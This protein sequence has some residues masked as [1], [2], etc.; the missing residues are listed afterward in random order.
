M[1]GIRPEE[2]VHPAKRSER[3]GRERAAVHDRSGG[4]FQPPKV[5]TQ[6]RQ[7][8]DALEE[9]VRSGHELLV[10]QDANVRLAEV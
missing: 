10:G 9:S 5:A 4:L 3:E 6:F 1:E 2:E 7:R 8:P